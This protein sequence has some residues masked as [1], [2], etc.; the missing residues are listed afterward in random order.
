MEGIS[1]FLLVGEG[2]Q[3]IEVTEGGQRLYTLPL[4]QRRKVL[5]FRLRKLF[6]QLYDLCAVFISCPV[7]LA[8]L[9]LVQ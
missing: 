1:G 7:R 2:A 8:D 6:V 4:L 9:S 5:L 3:A